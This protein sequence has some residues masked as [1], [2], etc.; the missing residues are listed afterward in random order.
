MLLPD[1]SPRAFEMI[2]SYIYTDKIQPSTKGRNNLA[3][4]D[5]LSSICQSYKLL[6]E[7]AAK[8]MIWKRGSFEIILAV[9]QNKSLRY[10][11]MAKE[12]F[13]IKNVRRC[14]GHLAQ[15]YM[16]TFFT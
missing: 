9:G 12:K 4:Q 16:F 13:I 5:Y 15:L 6:V 3:F 11:D 10:L 1:K 2:L 8:T 7:Y 14:K